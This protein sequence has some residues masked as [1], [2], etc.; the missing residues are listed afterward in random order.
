M[1]NDLFIEWRPG[2]VRP[3]REIKGRDYRLEAK[4]DLNQFREML[5]KCVLYYNNSYRMKKY[6]KDEFMIPK[7]VEPVPIQLWNYGMKHR[8]GKLRWESPEKIH[9]NL[10]PRGKAS[11]TPQGIY[12]K[13][14]Y[15]T[16]EMAMQEQLFVRSKGRRTTRFSIVSEPLVDRIHLRL[17]R[18]RHFVTCDLTPAD[19]R[20]QGRDW[21]EMQEYFALERQAEKDA[22]TEVQQS[23]ADHHAVVN[24]I[25]AE[26]TKMTNAALA[27]A[28]LS[29]NA[30]IK[31]IRN[32]RKALKSHE[33]KNGAGEA[34]E[35]SSS[36]PQD[37]MDK[38]KV[39]KFRKPSKPDDPGY[40][41][42][43]RPYDE[44]REA[45]K[46]ALENGE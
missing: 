19:R 25:I 17:D 2:E 15:Y 16:C 21:Y 26:G 3:R 27:E 40:V 46:E 10:L 35:K 20:F 32:N 33:R 45:R 23:K 44:L 36:K 31:G 43:A 28:G 22:E 11:T 4:L 34:A 7:K 12:Y 9:L 42:P 38:G 6:R 41:P 30:R 1:I 24:S 5:I 13:G 37:S 39:V 18:G 14:L 8:T 29:N